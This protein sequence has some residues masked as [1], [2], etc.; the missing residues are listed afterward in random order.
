MFNLI[1]ITTF[2]VV[3]LSIL[4]ELCLIIKL[5][6]VL[7]LLSIEN[8]TFSFKNCTKFI[9]LKK[10]SLKFIFLDFLVNLMKKVPYKFIRKKKNKCNF[11]L[12]L[13]LVC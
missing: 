11:I 5:K 12:I 8:F 7:L 2:Q 4:I 10:N 3:V 1:H 13:I 6:T 9:L